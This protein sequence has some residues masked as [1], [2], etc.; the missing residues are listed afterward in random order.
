MLGI[1]GDQTAKEAFSLANRAR[2]GVIVCFKIK[3]AGSRYFKLSMSR[4]VK[5]SDVELYVPDV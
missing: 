5:R 1:C 2:Y 4:L 3:K